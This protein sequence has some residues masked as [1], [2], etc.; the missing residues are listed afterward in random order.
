MTTAPTSQT[1]LYMTLSLSSTA[2]SQPRDVWI[3]TSWRN[4][5]WHLAF[6][7]NKDVLRC[8]G[9]RL[10]ANV[11]ARGNDPGIIGARRV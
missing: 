3:A 2:P 10:S 8:A 11:L 1:M 9:D 4:V 6:C 7:H 5:P